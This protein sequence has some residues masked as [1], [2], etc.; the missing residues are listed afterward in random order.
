MARQQKLQALVLSRRKVG[1]ADRLISFFTR[2]NGLVKAV[3]KGVRKI[4]STRGSHL[5]PFTETLVVLHTSPAG[6]YVSGAETQTYFSDLKTNQSAFEHAKHITSLVITLFGEDDA[7][8]RVHDMLR[9]SWNILPQLSQAKQNQLESAATIMMLSEAG[10]LPSWQTC[11]ACG[12]ATPRDAVVLD[13]VGGWRCITCHTAFS[14]TRWSL[15]PRLFK[16]L[17]YVSVN[18]EHAL[19]LALTPDESTQLVMSLRY[20]TGGLLQQ[21]LVGT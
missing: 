2:E 9:Y 21:T 11:E 18:P 8:P 4:P 20:F 10:V 6:T 17:R 16:V 13:P 1:E 7:H 14:G 3:A 12:E 19:R 5:E 15:P